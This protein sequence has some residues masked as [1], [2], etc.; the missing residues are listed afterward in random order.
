MKLISSV[1][2]WLRR[3]LPLILVLAL[4][5][6]VLIEIVTFLY[7]VGGSGFG[8]SIDADGNVVPAKTLWDW[9]ELLIVPLIL[10]IGGITINSAVQRSEREQ[11][12]QR[13]QLEKQQAE[14]RAEIDRQIADDRLKEQALQTYLDRMGEL[15][16]SGRFDNPE[17]Q[18][19]AWAAAKARTLT[20]L[21]GLNGERKGA[22]LQF[23]YE[24][25]LLTGEATL[26]LEK[27][28]FSGANL[29]GVNLAGANLN[30]ANLKGAVFEHAFLDGAYFGL[31]YLKEAKFSQASL[32]SADFSMSDL[33]EADFYKAFLTGTNFG[34]AT[35]KD[36]N[37][38]AAVANNA[39][40]EQA[41]LRGAKLNL[42][43]FFGANLRGALMTT[44]QVK[45]P[46]CDSNTILP[47]GTHYKPPSPPDDN[48][49]QE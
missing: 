9:L 39:Q 30:G 23:L 5:A 8:T 7:A 6:V 22:V 47:D 42:A 20:T 3:R 46:L 27:A 2:Q 28:D 15:L 21:R 38:R 17:T 10:A 37:L 19:R 43:T 45:A 1:S 29:E 41:E 26:N 14:Q 32:N 18:G 33:T 16:L 24:S 36:A 11:A 31:A 35:L 25:G 34:M 48:E 13:A 44:D 4:V 12:E 40:F 49:A